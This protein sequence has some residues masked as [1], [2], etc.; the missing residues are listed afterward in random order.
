MRIIAGTFRGHRL[1]CKA[2][3]S[4]RPTGERMRESLFSALGGVVSGAVVC[5]LFSGSGALGFEALSR[6]AEHV[7]LVERKAHLVKKLERTAAEWGVKNSCRVICA[8]VISWLNGA[9]CE[10]SFDLVF[11]DPPFATDYAPRV[12]D[13]WLATAAESAVLV[14]ELPAGSGDPGA[15]AGVAPVKAAEFGESSYR[16]YQQAGG[17][18]NR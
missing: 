5:D 17:E 2:G 9:G 11:A 15:Q 6:G 13:W 14:L 4:L 1:H 10:S 3:P 18:E 12:F 8:D 16:I 7:T